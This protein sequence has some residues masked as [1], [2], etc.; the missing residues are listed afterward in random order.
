M[1]S[2]KQ[3]AS[4]CAEIALLRMYGVPEWK[5]REIA[6]GMVKDYDFLF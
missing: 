4:D 1:T 2:I 6:E 5:I 3:I